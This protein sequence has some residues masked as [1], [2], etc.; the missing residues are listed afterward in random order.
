MKLAVDGAQM[1]RAEMTGRSWRGAQDIESIFATYKTISPYDIT[2]IVPNLIL[3]WVLR[4]I[5]GHIHH[6]PINMRDKW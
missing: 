6:A 3:S 5:L 1:A 4:F 2:Y